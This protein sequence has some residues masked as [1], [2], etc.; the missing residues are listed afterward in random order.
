MV[1]S[2]IK[3]CTG[4]NG[5]REERHIDGTSDAEEVSSGCREEMMI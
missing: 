1:R 4:Y 5:D 3:L 2:M